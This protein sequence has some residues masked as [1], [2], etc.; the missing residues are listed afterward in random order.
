LA[1][2]A[3]AREARAEKGSGQRVL[4]I[5][6]DDQMR[7]A[8]K[9]VLTSQGYAVVEQGDPRKALDYLRETDTEIALVV[10]DVVMPHMDGPSL[11]EAARAIRPSLRVLYISGYPDLP[12]RRALAPDESLLRKPFSTATLAQAVRTAIG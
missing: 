8:A 10:T 12:G 3:V 11:A 5:D 6:D 4:L 2:E 7:R 9:R 1:G